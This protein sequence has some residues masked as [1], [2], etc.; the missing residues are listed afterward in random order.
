[1][2]QLVEFSSFIFLVVSCS[3]QDRKKTLKK[4]NILPE[5]YQM[6]QSQMTKT[7]KDEEK[8]ELK[9]NQPEKSRNDQKRKV[10]YIQ[11]A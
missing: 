5:S 1:M 7:K 9:V 10:I 3:L 6:E 11:S 8:R 4:I 2:L